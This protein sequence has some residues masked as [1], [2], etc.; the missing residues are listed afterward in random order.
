[1]Y[2]REELKVD[3][4]IDWTLTHD[5]YIEFFHKS[6]A[7]S[8]MDAMEARIK[9]LEAI[10]DLDPRTNLSLVNENQQL[11]DRIKELEA[12]VI[13]YKASLERV[14]FKMCEKD[15]RIKELEKGAK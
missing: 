14:N 7:D 3:K 12:E 10:L 1:M 2:G 13:G 4:A 11:R 6:E 8:V 15:A 9:H 5:K